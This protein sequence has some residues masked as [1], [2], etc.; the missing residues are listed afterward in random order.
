MSEF[1][2]FLVEV[3]PLAIIIGIAAACIGYTAWGIIVPLGFVGFGFSIFDAIVIS[4]LVDFVNS[5]ILTTTYIKKDKVDLKEGTK[6]GMVALIGAIIGAILAILFL[7]RFESLLRGGVAYVFFLLAA[8]F[9]YR[10][11]KLGKKEKLSSEQQESHKPKRQLSE[12]LKTRIMITGFVVSGF[13]SGFIG[14]GGGS[15][16]TLLFLLIYGKE[17]GFDTL[18]SAGTGNYVMCILTVALT[19]IFSIAGLV[20]FTFIWPYLLV[21]LIP[22][23][24]GTIIGAKIALKV[25][26]SKLNYLVGISITITAIAATIQ[27]IML[28]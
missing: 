6:W 26:E 24:I 19:I 21:A 8:F 14:I 28:G 18:K 1:L 7:S 12:K 16:C 10:G 17:K 5:F 20:D 13:L 27:K 25:P 11:Y 3:I 4:L 22:S 2:L 9:I 23:A 15:N